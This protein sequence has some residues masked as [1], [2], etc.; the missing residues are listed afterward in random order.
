MLLFQGMAEFLCS[1]D[2]GT[3]LREH[4]DSQDCWKELECVGNAFG[5]FAGDPNAVALVVVDGRT[6]VPAVDAM[7]CP[8]SEL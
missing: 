3:L 6:N 8:C 1:S 5:L 2:C 4:W 7:G